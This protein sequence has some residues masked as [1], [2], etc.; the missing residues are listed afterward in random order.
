MYIREAVFGC[1]NIWPQIP[2]KGTRPIRA[3]IGG[4]WKQQ[5]VGDGDWT[6]VSIRAVC[7]LNYWTNSF[8]YGITSVLY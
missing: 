7:A 3:R 5:D 2:E 1:V 4:D 8:D 6:W